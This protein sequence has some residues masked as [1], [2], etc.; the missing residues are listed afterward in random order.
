MA[1]GTSGASPFS[2]AEFETASQKNR[3]TWKTKLRRSGKIGVAA[4]SAPESVR[5]YIA[6]QAPGIRSLVS[7]EPDVETDQEELCNPTLY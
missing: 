6:S 1:L 7:I 3:R 4:T 5:H 2:H